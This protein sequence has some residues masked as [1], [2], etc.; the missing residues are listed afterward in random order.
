MLLL[1]LFAP[2]A[3]AAC[4]VDQVKSDEGVEIAV[5][6]LQEPVGCRTVTLTSD[7]PLEVEAYVW[8]PEERRTRLKADHLRALPGGGWE[9]G[10]P[11]LVP[12]GWIHLRV[13]VPG[14][15]LDLRLAPAPEP[16][17]RVL[18]AD[19]THTLT[20]DPRHPGWG[21]ADRARART[22]VQ[23]ALGL[24]ADAPD[25]V[26]PLPSG[27]IELDTGGLPTVPHG[28][29]LPA[30]TTEA[31]VTYTVKGAAPQG[32]RTLAPGS[33]TLVGPDVTWR[34]SVG[35]GVRVG[36]VEGGVRF[37]A[38][39]GGAA[40]WRVERAGD[41]AVIPDVGTFVAG[42]DWRFA[43]VSLPE[44]AVP[45]ELR[46][47]RD[48]AELFADLLAAVRGLRDGAL[49]GAD[50]LHPRQLNKAWRSG[51]VTPVE[52]ALVLHRFLGQERYRAGWVLTGEDADP[53]T[54]TGF[55]HLLVTA[56][57]EGE[58]R[59][60]DPT[61]AVCAPGEIGTRWL[62]RPAIGVDVT[63]GNEDAG[64][65]ETARTASAPMSPLPEGATV[66]RAEGRL[67][68]SLT[69]QG[70]RFRARFV[71]RGAA[72]LWLRERIVG[73][74]PAARGMRLGEALGMPDA[75][76]VEAA[77][78]GEAGA[79]ITVELDGPRPPLDPFPGPDATP[80]AGG[81][82]DVL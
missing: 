54:L 79:P 10:A 32:A 41:A 23:L 16:D 13:A 57:V 34:T 43:R 12:G 27:V 40:R 8:S 70:E 11:E 56:Y 29:K 31:R 66:P 49:P 38:P 80:W 82:G 21:F 61:C 55:D 9:I 64:Q 7:R 78:F 58:L 68:R 47:K 4:A 1:S 60:I 6:A 36:E 30:G 74:E 3:H 15:A 28:V 19:E 67:E 53:A 52:R 20:L 65:K 51:W 22:R 17:L 46:G 18:R 33:L 45:M 73:V 77:G 71:A 69:L 72:A 75:A 24:P 44:P 35:P 37:E 14:D 76:L 26:L 25:Q 5:R 48:R 62:G 59:W 39:E 63:S 2:P 81:W 50:P 42:L